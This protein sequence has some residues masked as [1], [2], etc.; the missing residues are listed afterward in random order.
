M[1]LSEIT[2]VS[3]CKD[4]DMNEVKT[5]QMMA[6]LEMVRNTKGAF[7]V[8]VREVDEFAAGHIPGAVN[9][10]L[11]ALSPAVSSSLTDMSAPVFVY[12]RSGRRSQMAG[13]KLVSFGYSDITNI[14]GILDYEGEQE[15]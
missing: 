4:V 2:A 14:D 9:I 15:K 10:P 5:V 11:S 7:L 3:G 13:E 12:C 1:L 6:G 8:D